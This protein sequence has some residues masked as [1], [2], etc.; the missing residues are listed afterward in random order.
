LKIIKPFDNGGFLVVA[1]RVGAWIE[2]I[3]PQVRHALLRSSRPAWARG[4]K[5]KRFG[6]IIVPY[7]VVAPRVGAWIETFSSPYQNATPQVAPRV[8][9]WIETYPAGK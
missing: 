5:H 2:E 4:L 3:E 9:A 1:P 7:P 6:F 8:G